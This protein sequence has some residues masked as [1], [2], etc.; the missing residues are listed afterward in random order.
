MTLN[1]FLNIYLITVSL[2]IILM[3]TDLHSGKIKQSIELILTKDKFKEFND[4][5]HRKRFFFMYLIVTLTLYSIP[6]I[7]IIVLIL[8]IIFNFIDDIELK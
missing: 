7:N 5:L 2:G 3:I 4:T 6:V 1:I 8:H